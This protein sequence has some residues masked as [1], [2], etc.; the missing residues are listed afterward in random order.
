MTLKR[1]SGILVYRNVEIDIRKQNSEIIE[2]DKGC[3]I[4]G[5]QKHLDVHEIIPRSAFGSKTMHLCF[6]PE[7]RVTLC[8]FHHEQAHTREVRKQ[9]Q[10]YI[11]N[12]QNEKHESI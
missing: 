12:L 10:E 7:N 9:L 2:R 8:R 3:V 5:A 1:N 6:V 11:R 4:C